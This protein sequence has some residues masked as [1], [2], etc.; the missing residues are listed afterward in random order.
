M[1]ELT[2]IKFGGSVITDKRGEEA[3]DLPLI[4][5]LAHELAQAWQAQPNRPLI[6][7][8]GS[9]SF[10]H[11]AAARYG[12]HKGIAPG[13]DWYGFAATSAAALRLNRIFV[14]ALVAAQ[15]PALS[16]QPSS[17]L[18]STAGKLQSWDTRTIS[19]ALQHG[20][21]PVVHGDVAF[22]SQQG[23]AIIST[24]QLFSYL[25][26][27]TTELQPSRIILVG[28]SGVYND[29]PH[30]NP[31]AKRIP[32]INQANIE[33]VLGGT[34]DSYGTDVTGGMRAKVSLMW[35][36]IEALPDLEVHLIGTKPGLLNRALLGQANDEGTRMRKE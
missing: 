32:L 35:S 7:G 3:A 24:E 33:A 34:G 29:D 16:L 28:E 5:R 8:H 1:S 31:D 10:G 18:L 36:L 15:L 12:I 27:Q 17:T 22:D 13:G 2:L 21:I 6:I 30:R 25:A 4:Q 23:S 20:L 14:D 19:Q 9:G 11:T 26:L